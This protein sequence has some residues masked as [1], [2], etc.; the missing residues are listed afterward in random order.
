M[1]LRGA[2]GLKSAE[3]AIDVL[4]DKSEITLR[5]FMI[6]LICLIISSTIQA[7]ILNSIRNALIVALCFGII[8]FLLY[9]YGL[10][11]KA[12]KF[13]TSFM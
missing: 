7:F 6:G 12:Y 5:L 11:E 8:S 9:N 10:F 13:L 4:H 3:K 2:E 1:F